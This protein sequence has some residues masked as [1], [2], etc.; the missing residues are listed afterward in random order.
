[1]LIAVPQ[2]LSSDQLAEVRRLVDAGEWRDGKATAGQQSEL[3]KR[4]LQLPSSDANAQA[5][6]RIVMDAIA[7]NG[8]F[9]SAALPDRV[10][11]PLFNR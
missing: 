6:G 7:N 9:M 11:P 5:A 1:M 10:F 8:L 2:V 4:N 3:A